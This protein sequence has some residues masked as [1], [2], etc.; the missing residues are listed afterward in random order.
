M[1]KA[2]V[3]LKALVIQRK[4]KEVC[5]AFDIS[6]KYCFNL[7]S[8]KAKRNPSWD[9][10]NKFRPIIPVDFWFE[11]ATQEFVDEILKNIKEN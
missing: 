11:N 3:I 4:L 8:N 10:M 5:E 9:V 1:T 6:Y 2:V 7:T